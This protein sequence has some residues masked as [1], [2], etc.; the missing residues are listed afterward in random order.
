MLVST[1][2]FRF[3]RSLDSTLSR[4]SSALFESS[5]STNRRLFQLEYWKA[6]WPEIEIGLRWDL[7]L[8]ELWLEGFIFPFD[9]LSLNEGMDFSFPCLKLVCLTSRKLWTKEGFAYPLPM[10][11]V[12]V[13][14]PSANWTPANGHGCVSVPTPNSA[15]WAR[16]NFSF[17]VTF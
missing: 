9:T 14:R 10:A 5:S 2:I 13:Q 16:T 8:G 6:H 3:V 17:D 7:L 4:T 15:C 11:F 1:S 12:C